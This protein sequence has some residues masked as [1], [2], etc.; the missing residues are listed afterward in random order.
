MERAE[1]VG[2][3]D[4]IYRKIYASE[5]EDTYDM[6]GAREWWNRIPMAEL[7]FELE[8]AKLKLAAMHVGR[9]ADVT[10]IDWGTY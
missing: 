10:V 4:E 2:K 5:P 3:L 9:G 1:M 7:Q 6:D 8:A